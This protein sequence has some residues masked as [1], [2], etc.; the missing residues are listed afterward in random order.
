MRNLIVS[1]GGVEVRFASNGAQEK[2]VYEKTAS[3]ETIRTTFVHDDFGN[4]TEERRS[5]ALSV[6]GDEVV[7]R[8]S[9]IND[10][11]RWILGAPSRVT[12]SDGAGRRL[13]ETMSYYDGADFEGLP[14][15]RLTGGT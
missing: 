12:V 15:G 11:S 5:G 1:P 3:P 6:A 2:I 7:T 8:T 4:V 14:F 9:Y 10:T 13:S